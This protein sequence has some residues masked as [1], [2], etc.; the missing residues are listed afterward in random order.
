MDR[1]AAGDEG[2]Q[3]A[4]ANLN[5]SGGGNLSTSGATVESPA[6]AAIDLSTGRVYWA[7]YGS[8]AKPIAYANLDGS[9]GGGDLN[10][11]GATAEGASLPAIDESGSGS[12]GRTGSGPPGQAGPPPNT[13]SL[14]GSKLKLNKKRG[15]ATLTLTLPDA[16]SLLLSGKGLR[17]VSGKSNGAGSSVPLLIKPVGKAK[18]KERRHHRLKVRFSVTFTPNGGTANTQSEKVTLKLRKKKRRR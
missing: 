8:K 7:N 4:F 9:G 6:G 2:K 10:T 1:A 17:K 11:A 15:T 5:G 12:L 16:G 3:I 13:F 14:S 18:K